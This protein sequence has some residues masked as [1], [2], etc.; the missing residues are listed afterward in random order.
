MVEMAAARF[1]K[2]EMPS[3]RPS[4]VHHNNIQDSPEKCKINAR[5]RL[6]LVEDRKSEEI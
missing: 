3:R 5:K 2:M 6:P 4:R 1:D